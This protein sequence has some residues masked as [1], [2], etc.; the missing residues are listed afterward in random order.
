M[1]K[2]SIFGST[3]SI[4]TQA[5]DVVKKHS[6]KFSVS[7]LAVYSNIDLLE[8][9]IRE[10]KPQNVAVFN[11]Q[12]A[13]ELRENIK[14][15]DVKVLEGM[16]GLCELASLDD[17]EILLN[18]VTGMIGLEPTLC[19]INAGKD[20]AL[21]NKETLVT[22][23]ELVMKTLKEKNVRMLPVDSE[24]SAIFQCLQGLNNEKELK[25]IIITA[26]GGP[27]FGKTIEEL[28]NVTPEKAL[29]HPNWDMGAKITIDSASMMNKG[30]E[31]IEA[32]WLF[33]LQPEQIDVVVHRES[34]IHSLVEFADNSVLAQ[35]G[36]PDMRIPIQYALTYPNRFESPAKQLNLWDFPN[37]SFY[38]A[39]LQNFKCL[40]IA[41]KALKRGG[42]SCTA[43]NAADE[44]AVDLFLKKKIKFTEIAELAQL[45]MDRISS[46]TEINLENILKAD[47]ETRDYVLSLV[48]SEK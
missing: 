23:G 11:L 24:H 8:K 37:L 41:I 1:K 44:V 40:D 14:D 30:L 27:F 28:K 3:G 18:S 35:L 45:A 25:R 19:A 31:V 43:I 46:Q 39:D 29:K 42:L 2:I 22:G 21:A 20:I 13:K 34:I 32:K 9:Q 15:L 12:K 36:L 26:S 33:G 16:Q 5:L 38:K 10:F 17:S 6:D 48:K 7:S 4:G 47:K